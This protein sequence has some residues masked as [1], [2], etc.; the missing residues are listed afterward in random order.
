[1]V[2]ADVNGRSASMNEIIA[3]LPET[4]P[5]SYVISSKGVTC[6]PDHLHFDAAG[7]REMG[8]RYATQILSLMGIEVK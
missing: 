3:R 1:V 6:A 7:Y 2:N 4:L 8:R 5:N